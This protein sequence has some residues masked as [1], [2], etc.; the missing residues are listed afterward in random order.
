MDRAT[1]PHV[2]SEEADGDPVIRKGATHA[3]Y[4]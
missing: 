4:R 2:D 3:G 1:G